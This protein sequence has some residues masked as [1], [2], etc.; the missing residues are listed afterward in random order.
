MVF[1]DDDQNPYE[2]IW[3]ATTFAVR[4]V[5]QYAYIDFYM[6]LCEFLYFSMAFYTFSVCLYRFLYFSTV[7][8]MDIDKFFCMPIVFHIFITKNGLVNIFELKNEGR[9]NI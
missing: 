1:D 6:L 5:F 9:E 3:I 2:F 8:Y 7:F 4:L